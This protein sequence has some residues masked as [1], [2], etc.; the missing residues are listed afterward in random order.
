[1]I[2]VLALTGAIYMLQ[3]YDRVLTTRHIPTLVGLTILMVGLYV[4]HG[5]LDYLRMRVM[6]KIGVEIAG[7]LRHR[8]FSAVQLLPLRLRQCGDGLQPVRDL[9]QVRSF[10]YRGL[11]R[12]PS[13]TCLGSRSTSPRFFSCIPLSA[14]SLTVLT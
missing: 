5:F 1:M 3:I 11:A 13:S 6:S 7:A 10:F 12:R 14:C 9:D 4:A 8:V 2:N